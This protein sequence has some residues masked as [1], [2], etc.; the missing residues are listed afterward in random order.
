M[1]PIFSLKKKPRPKEKGA[2]SALK[3]GQAVARPKEKGSWSALKRGQ[4]VA[5]PKKERGPCRP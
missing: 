5:G 2:K 3:R 1:L 4:A